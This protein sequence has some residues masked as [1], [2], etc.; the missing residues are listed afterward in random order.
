[1]SVVAQLSPP[2]Q[3]PKV[4]RDQH[5]R[6]EDT[7]KQNRNPSEDDLI[8]LAVEIGLSEDEVLVGIFWVV[9]RLLPEYTW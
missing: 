3:L 7:F 4:R 9:R 5:K 8:L 2:H 1:M 6:L